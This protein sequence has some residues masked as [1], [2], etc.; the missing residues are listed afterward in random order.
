MVQLVEGGPSP[1]SAQAAS[2]AVDMPQRKWLPEHKALLTR[3]SLSVF[4]PLLDLAGLALVGW[5][6]YEVSLD[7]ATRDRFSAIDQGLI[8][9]VFTA[10]TTM[11]AALVCLT[12]HAFGGYRPQVASRAG[13]SAAAVA[14]GILSVSGSLFVLQALTPMPHSL[15]L[16]L[17]AS[18]VIAI[19]AAA[20]W[21]LLAARLITPL[22]AATAIP[23]TAVVLGAGPEARRFL[24]HLSTNTAS[25]PR[26][27]GCFDD[28][29][30]RVSNALCGVQCRGTV[31]D[32]IGFVREHAVDEVI[33]ALP[34]TAE[35][36][37]TALIERLK[38]LPVDIRLS[39]YGI[40]YRIAEPRIA[41]AGTLPLLT[42]VPRPLTPPDTVAKTIED[43][44][45]GVGLLVLFLPIMAIIAIAIRLDS[46]GP[47]FFRQPRHGWND[48]VIRVFKFRT[49]IDSATDVSG[50]RQTTR[51]DDR[52]TRVGRFLR[53][54]SLDEIPQLIN[55]VRGE[56]SV[57]GPRPHPIGMK[58]EEKL[59]HEIVS[60]YAQRHKMKPG[61]TGWAQIHGWRGA[62]ETS[63]QLRKRVE[64]DIYYVENWS[65]WLD[66]KI[67]LMTA[68]KGFGGPNAF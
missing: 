41:S 61:I 24:E 22:L 59:C 67:L 3:L 62:T 45:L 66:F 38:V 31:D 32:L 47:I 37:L 13:A 26:I 52:I 57:I 28:R 56:M 6:G 36:R 16:W 8:P 51:D 5:L 18:C 50:T 15:M 33:I 29:A 63:Y 48:R 12:V 14:M 23:R 35:D 60:G 58:T 34:W 42:A 20:A 7:Q 11:C 46:P 21:R 19:P 44:L 17:A 43:W 65:L 54:T 27:L 64:H 53:R 39:P 4:L 68:V 2:R 1:R 10:A 9:G 25:R 55:V 49:M 30:T 40:S